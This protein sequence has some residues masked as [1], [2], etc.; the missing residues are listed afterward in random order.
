MI[1]G[2]ATFVKKVA[3]TIS[4]KVKKSDF[5]RIFRIFLGFFGT[6]WTTFGQLWTTFGQLYRN[7]IMKKYLK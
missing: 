5:F 2:V 6:G 4:E 7:I 3:D 1:N